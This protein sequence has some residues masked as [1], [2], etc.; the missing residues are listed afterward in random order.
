M[1]TDFILAHD[2]GTS[3]TKTS[4]VRPDGVV[5][6]SH[7][8]PHGTRVPQPGWAE[9]DPADWWEGVCKNTR[10]VF[11]QR[12]ELKGRIAA[13]GVSGQMMGLVSVDANG[14]VLRPSMIH[15][16][17][18][19]VEECRALADSVGAEALYRRTGNI[20]D[21]RSS[22]CKIL[23]MKN[24]EPGVLRRTARIVQSKD[25]IVGRMVGS[26]D[27]TDMSDASHAQFIDITRKAYI[28]DVFGELGIDAGKFP[29][30]H[31]S[32]D[33][34]GK[35][36]KAG[37]EE[38][39]LPEGVPV[40]AGGGDGA[41][42]SVGAGAVGP[43]DTYCCIGTT[44]WISAAVAEPFIDEKRRIFSILALD[45]ESCG[46]YGTIQCAGRSVEW[47]LDLLGEDGFDRFDELLN[48]VEPGSD[49]LIFLPYLEGERSPI[50]DSNAR[51]VFFGITPEHGRE[52]FVRATIEGVS[53]ALRSV[54]DVI[55]ESQSVS[56]LRLIGGG[57]QSTV[58][59]QLLAD[60]CEVNVQM[61]STQSADAT[62][63]GAAIAAGVGVGMFADLAEGVRT[64]AV[65]DQRPPDLSRSAL[66]A[67]QYEIYGSLYPCLK[68]AFGRLQQCVADTKS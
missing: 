61:L 44:A 40:V 16:D 17:C 1:P 3:G 52:H 64:I 46:L 15:S 31:P 62:S 4:L 55:R 22:L 19:A 13:I 32:T 2:I 37:A 24:N 60:V 10:A 38:L 14:D 23:W 28:D 35:L 8:T 63:L 58:W 21:P 59:Q 49:G 12:P 57:G 36:T 39:G 50:F 45:G 29:E 25:Y 41:C 54:L 33:V 30:L 68:P 65:T 67:K 66:Y 20:L 11:D 18:R 42:A 56:A 5:E 6:T 51:G 43:G 26:F 34:V 53:F 47:V 9:Q 27:T 48:S 7:S